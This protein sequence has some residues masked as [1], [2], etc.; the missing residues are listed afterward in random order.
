MAVTLLTACM[1]T[2]GSIRLASIHQLETSEIIAGEEF[3]IFGDGFVPGQ[4]E[5][6]LDG[7]WVVAGSRPRRSSISF[8]GNAVTEREISTVLPLD[9]HDKLGAPHALFEGT[10]H[11]RFAASNRVRMGYIEAV[12]SRIVL[13]VLSNEPN[14]GRE[15]S[16]L[17]KRTESFLEHVGVKGESDPDGGF[18]LTDVRAEGPAFTA[19]LAS[20]DLVLVSRGMRVYSELDLLPAPTAREIAW[21]VGRTDAS[22]SRHLRTFT[23]SIPAQA[24]E[25]GTDPAW[26]VSGASALSIVLFSGELFVILLAPVAGLRRLVSRL[27]SRLRSRSGHIV[28]LTEEPPTPAVPPS[29]WAQNLVTL[30]L[31]LAVASGCAAVMLSWADSL[32]LVPVYALLVMLAWLTGYRASR[33]QSPSTMSSMRRLLVCLLAPAPVAF[34]F[35]W[36][37]LFTLSP[38]LGALAR[39]QGL[40]PWTWHG[41]SD[42]FAFLILVLA[43]LSSGLPERR[44]VGLARHAA[45]QIYTLVSCSV[46][47]HVMLGGL[48][49]LPMGGVQGSARATGLGLLLWMSKALALYLLVQAQVRD[50]ADSSVSDAWILLFWPAI[51]TGALVGSVMLGPTMESALPSLPRFT[52]A[53]AAVLVLG[54]ASTG[55]ASTR[56][57][58]IRI[59]PW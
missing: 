26:I 46:V 16:A 12:R 50:R 34:I 22:G 9:A 44:D 3:K 13:D 25:R 32:H 2:G 21:V 56:T 27:V 17:G 52:A 59:H 31:V 45:H 11:A 47:A 30:P 36:R 29:R 4:V 10:V 54:L 18:L 39:G 7:D 23:L 35:I 37:S 40:E 28:S 58:A 55:Q 1:A 15:A 38:T 24:L 48:A 49:A 8:F 42:P 14:G 51:L 20:G 41:L 57:S 5:I 53:A 33:T 43:V 6:V 19:G